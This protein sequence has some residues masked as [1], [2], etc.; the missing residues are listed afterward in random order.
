MCCVLLPGKEEWKTT[1][2]IC[3]GGPGNVVFVVDD[4]P[5]GGREEEV[6]LCL[7]QRRDGGE[8]GSCECCE[9]HRRNWSRMI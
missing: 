3:I 4:Q 6:E 7:G 5:V 8:E 9:V 1:Y 2:I